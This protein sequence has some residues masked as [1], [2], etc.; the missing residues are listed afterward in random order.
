MIHCPTDRTP[1]TRGVHLQPALPQIDVPPRLHH[2]RPRARLPK[3]LRTHLGDEVLAERRQLLARPQRDLRARRSVAHEQAQI[4]RQIRAL[5]REEQ[6]A[7][8]FLLC[9]TTGRQRMRVREKT[10]SEWRGGEKPKAGG[11]PDSAHPQAPDAENDE[12]H[13]RGVNRPRIA[14]LQPR[15]E[16]G[17]RTPW[18]TQMRRLHPEANR[19]SA[20]GKTTDWAERSHPEANRGKDER[21]TAS[22]D[23][24]RSSVQPLPTAQQQPLPMGQQID[25]D[26]GTERHKRETVVSGGASDQPTRNGAIVKQRSEP[27]WTEEK[28]EKR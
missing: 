23:D 13:D 9:P 3:S 22:S 7:V 10:V 6:R 25:H 27:I 26:F 11:T 5:L 4:V 17:P 24:G 2:V 18:L 28:R 1:P 14:V 12:A 21:K 19:A 15:S 20:L 8:A 16:S